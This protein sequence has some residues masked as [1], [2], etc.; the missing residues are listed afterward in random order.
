MITHEERLKILS[1][2]FSMTRFIFSNLNIAKHSD[3]L[4]ED[5]IF[6]R[7]TYQHS[8]AHPRDSSAVVSLARVKVFVEFRHEIRRDVGDSYQ[9]YA[10]C[11]VEPVARAY[12]RGEDFLVEFSEEEWHNYL[13]ITSI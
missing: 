4:L 8:D 5:V 11:P 2:V 12:E 1:S 6:A 3:L 13:D 9:L 7:V 10:H